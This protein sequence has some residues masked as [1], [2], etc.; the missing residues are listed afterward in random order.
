VLD[1]I[2]ETDRLRDLA[3]FGVDLRVRWAR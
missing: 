2:G 1:D 3:D